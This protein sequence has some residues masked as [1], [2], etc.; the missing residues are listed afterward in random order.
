M[1]AVDTGLAGKKPS[2]TQKNPCFASKDV[3][4]SAT[5][6]KVLYLTLTSFLLVRLFAMWAVPFTDTTEARYG[7]IARK[8]V[9]TG[10]WI[11]PQI[12]YGVPFWAKPPLHTWLSA[13]GMELFGISEFAARLPIFLTSL[14][15]YQAWVLPQR[16]MT[17]RKRSKVQSIQF[18]KVF[19]S[20]AQTTSEV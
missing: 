19:S 5:S 4:L 14:A 7:E 6:L 1:T 13:G 9:E 16:Q 3:W 15:M 12:D 2:G 18:L 8:M 11:T 10:N 17:E 20:R